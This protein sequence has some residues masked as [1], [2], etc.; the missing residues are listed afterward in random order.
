LK[1]QELIK[2]AKM[3][4]TVTEAVN[5]RIVALR[6]RRRLFLPALTNTD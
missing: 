5:D 3:P 4:G 6:T 2:P 1:F